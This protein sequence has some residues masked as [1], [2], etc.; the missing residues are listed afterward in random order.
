[1]KKNIILIALLFGLGGLAYYLWLE[2]SKTEKSTITADRGFTVASMNEVSRLVI[3]R[4][5]EPPM[6]FTRRGEDWLL[7]EKYD[8][9]PGVFVNIE[10]VLTKMRLSY[11]PNEAAIPNIKESIKKSGIQVDVYGKDEK[12]M[13]IF[14][15]GS[16]APQGSG[17]YMWLS[18]E[19][20]P[21]V[22]QLP[23]VAGGLRSRFDQP[24]HN[25]RNKMI[26]NHR[27]EDIESIKVEYPKDNFSSF[28]IEKTLMGAEVKPLLD[29]PQKTEK[30]L[31]KVTLDRYINNFSSMGI[32]GN[33]NAFPGKDSIV[34]AIPNCILTIEKKGGQVIQH[35]FWSHDNY[36]DNKGTSRT[37]EEIRQQERMFILTQDND[38][39]LAQQRVIGKIF[40]GYEDFFQ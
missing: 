36:L 33:I 39:Y 22:M 14:F 35:K 12:P 8:V 32:E 34:V 29:L 37:P 17:T 27:K 25:Y 6:V 18:G 19:D 4:A 7:N 2:N 30:T 28:L 40:L 15:V 5:E 3:K 21:F 26:Y 23:G 13:K 24:F 11:V 9:D 1:M 16:D 31:N 38:F 10:V 20:T